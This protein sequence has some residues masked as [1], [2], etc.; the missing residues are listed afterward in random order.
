MRRRDDEAE[1][2]NTRRRFAGCAGDLER[3]RRSRFDELAE[4][5]G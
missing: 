1:L 5:D 3:A 2:A 4:R